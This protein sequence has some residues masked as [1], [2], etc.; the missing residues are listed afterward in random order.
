MNGRRYHYDD[1]HHNSYNHNYKEPYEYGQYNLN[2]YFLNHR[3]KNYNN[4]FNSYEKKNNKNN[5]KINLDQTLT[6]ISDKVN[7]ILSI[8]NYENTTT[9]DVRYLWDVL[10]PLFKLALLNQ[11]QVKDFGFDVT[12]KVNNNVSSILW[13]SLNA[14]IA[15]FLDN[16]RESILNLTFEQWNWVDSNSKYADSVLLTFMPKKIVKN[17]Q[18][19]MSYLNYIA[20]SSKIDITALKSNF[21]NASQSSSSNGQYL[22]QAFLDRFSCELFSSFHIYNLKFYSLKS[23]FEI[24]TSLFTSYKGNQKGAYAII[25]KAFQKLNQL[26]RSINLNES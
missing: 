23:F 4:F 13:S 21:L 17:F 7:T 12:Q 8:V 5:N 26:Y 16:Q 2:I 25:T 11:S 14:D 22:A 10:D 15:S 24:F 20:F 9:N 19:I 1:Y 18:K 6:A 3:D